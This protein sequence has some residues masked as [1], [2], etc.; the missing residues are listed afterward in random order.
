VVLQRLFF[1]K[2]TSFPV[3]IWDAQSINGAPPP[4]RIEQ[5]ERPTLLDRQELIKRSKPNLSNLIDIDRARAVLLQ[6]A[7]KTD[8]AA[9][10]VIWPTF[11]ERVREFFYNLFRSAQPDGKPVSYQAK[12]VETL[13]KRK[14]LVPFPNTPNTEH[15]NWEIAETPEEILLDFCPPSI[16]IA[17]SDMPVIS[18]APQERLDEL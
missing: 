8:T 12:R 13:I 4:K 18:K 7:E 17:I 10:M 15:L 16:Q 6:D 1:P 11:F 9:L 3:P 14:R 2:V 5:D